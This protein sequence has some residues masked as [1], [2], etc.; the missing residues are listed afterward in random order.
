MI[1]ITSK[2]PK[3]QGKVNKCV[4]ALNRYYSLNDLRNIA[5]DSGNEKEVRKYDRMCEDVFD[6]YLTYLESL[7]KYEQTQIKKY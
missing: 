6:K 5:D 4:K 7:P 2:N 3:N 1:T